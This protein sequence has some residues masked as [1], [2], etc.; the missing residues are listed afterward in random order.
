MVQMHLMMRYLINIMATGNKIIIVCEDCK[1]SMF[2]FAQEEIAATLPVGNVVNIRR[3]VE[4][5]GNQEHSITIIAPRVDAL[6]KELFDL[7]IDFAERELSL[8]QQI[9]RVSE[10]YESVVLMKG[11]GVFFDDVIDQIVNQKSGLENIAVIKKLE[12]EEQSIDYICANAGEYVEQFIAY[13]RLHYVNARSCGIFKLSR[14]ALDVFRFAQPGFDNINCGQMPDNQCHL[15]Q[16]IQLAIEQG[17]LFASLWCQKFVSL[18]FPWD[19]RHANELYC[20]EEIQM[21]T[22]NLKSDDCY[23]SDNCILQGKLKVGK[24]VRI[25]HGVIIE[26]NCIVGD[27]VTIEKNAIIGKNCMIGSNSIVQYGCRINDYTILGEKNK[28]GFNAEIS[29]V[30]FKGVCAVHSSEV[31]GVIGKYVDIAAGV[32]M[33]VL[34]FNDTQVEQRVQGKTYRNK[35]TNSIFLGDY[36][37]TGIGNLFYPGVKIGSKSAIGPG[38]IISKDVPSETLLLVEQT[39]ILKQWGSNRYGW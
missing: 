1:A 37:R 5:C 2:P 9:Y 30:T 6:K 27:D 7:D 29:G 36:C 24:R 16:G 31:F 33:G 8:F 39:H 20:S 10:N 14:K 12:N 35:Y 26:G 38:A 25:E 18:N 17:H 11:E 23:I 13:A 3:L 32:Q 15:E 19:I 34:K 22:E 21:L 28:I 4:A